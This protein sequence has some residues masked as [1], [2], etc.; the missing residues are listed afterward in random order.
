MKIR[1]LLGFIAFALYAPF[2]FGSGLDMSPAKTVCTI[3]CTHG[4]M[5]VCHRICVPT[6]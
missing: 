5:P 6:N 2:G 3:N 4:P 1:T